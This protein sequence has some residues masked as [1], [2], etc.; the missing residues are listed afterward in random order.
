MTI[1]KVAVIGAGSMGSGIAALC[2]SAGLDVVLL[3]QNAEGAQKGVVIGGSDA[4]GVRRQVEAAALSTRSTR[5]SS[6]TS[7]PRPS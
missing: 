6:H 4:G 1:T 7:S 2:A 5:P 3:D